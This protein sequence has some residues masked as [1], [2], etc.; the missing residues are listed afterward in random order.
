[1]LWFQNDSLD[2]VGFLTASLN[3]LVGHQ[4]SYLLGKWIFV[5]K[6][7]IGDVDVTD[8]MKW[9]HNQEKEFFPRLNNIFGK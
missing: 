4:K 5:Q 8:R 9:G 6:S 1:M 3:Y 7:H 2:S